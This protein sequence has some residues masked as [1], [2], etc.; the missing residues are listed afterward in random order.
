MSKQTK[1]SPRSWQEKLNAAAELQKRCETK[2]GE[3]RALLWER[4]RLLVEVF[5]DPDWRAKFPGKD[6]AWL[7]DELSK[8]LADTDFAFHDLRIILVYFPDRESWAQ[9]VLVDLYDEAR[10]KRAEPADNGPRKR[11]SVKV[12]E[13]EEVVRQ[14]Q[15]LERQLCQLQ[16]MPTEVER[17]REENEQL[18][19]EVYTL[20]KANER[21][22]AQLDELAVSTS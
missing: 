17:L 15:A 22:R 20:R 3:L 2:R 1:T 5:D 13:H 18:R 12:C 16:D 21:L 9:R 7:G 4:V 6:D 14:K 11:R 8:Y 19:R 10:S